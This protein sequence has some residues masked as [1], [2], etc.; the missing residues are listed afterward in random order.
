MSAGEYVGQDGRTYRTV[1]GGLW[2][3]KPVVEYQCSDTFGGW[4][5]MPGPLEADWPAAKAALD[6]LIEADAGE[7][8]HFGGWTNYRCRPNGDEP[9]YDDGG[10]WQPVDDDGQWPTIYRKGRAVA[11]EQA[12]KECQERI[13]ALGV[14]H[15]TFVEQVQE[16]VRMVLA[17]DE[18][19]SVPDSL[20]DLAKALK[21]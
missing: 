4:V 14:E 20:R 18:R 7:W 5:E 1:R 16:L 13:Y 2:C 6:A 19:V 10:E 17:Y 8:I 9:Q 15:R 12:E 21:R 3:G 11:L